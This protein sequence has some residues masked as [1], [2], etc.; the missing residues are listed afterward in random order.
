MMNWY[1]C[2]QVAVKTVIPQRALQ[3]NGCDG[4]VRES[5][6]ALLGMH[7]A[8]KD[9][10]T[11]AAAVAAQSGN[12]G[13]A[14]LPGIVVRTP[15]PTG[16]HG[17]PP[18]PGSAEAGG[19]AALAAPRAAAVPKAL[20]HCASDK[21][22]AEHAVSVAACNVGVAGSTKCAPRRQQTIVEIKEKQRQRQCAAAETASAMVACQESA[23]QEHGRPSTRAPV[24]QHRNISP[25]DSSMDSMPFMPPTLPPAYAQAPVPPSVTPTEKRWARFAEPAPP[26]MGCFQPRIGGGE[27][28]GAVS[29]LPLLSSYPKG[30]RAAALSSPAATAVLISKQVSLGDGAPAAAATSGT[31]PVG[32][33][34][35]LRA[36]GAHE[37]WQQESPFA[38]FRCST[39]PGTACG[40][41]HVPAFTNESFFD[42]MQCHLSAHSN[43]GP[44]L[45]VAN[46]RS[47]SIT[48]EPMSADPTARRPTHPT[49]PAIPG[50]IALQAKLPNS[51]AALPAVGIAAAAKPARVSSY[52]SSRQG[53]LVGVKRPVPVSSSAGALQQA[54]PALPPS[55]P[56]PALLKVP[57]LAWLSSKYA[58]PAAS[59]GSPAVRGLLA[60]VAPKK[61]REAA[62]DPA[63]PTHGEGPAEGVRTGG[64]AA[65][66]E[67]S[68]VFDFL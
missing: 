35:S 60:T 19:S 56:G 61:D 55:H 45:A 43:V 54:M 68:G 66:H 10:P 44:F 29:M 28:V 9:P 47:G 31:V 22:G 18:S 42:S 7:V 14:A 65:D 67:F 40:Q 5:E 34:G 46:K 3:R 30:P 36:H 58:E 62:L 23:G 49:R 26:G 2:V 1:F 8:Q 32:G 41:Y 17:L 27:E 57:K 25:I 64:P 53:V 51:Q 50:L 38:L 16:G 20:A 37:E 24:Q 39:K 4:G 6:A 12:S 63:A 21:G 59:S 48:E 13:A 52:T 33:D 11:A 15:N